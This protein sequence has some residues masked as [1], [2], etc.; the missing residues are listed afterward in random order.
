MAKQYSNLSN[1][2]VVT[3]WSNEVTYLP[4]EIKASYVTGNLPTGYELLGHVGYST[5]SPE[6][7]IVNIYKSDTN[8]IRF[9]IRNMNSNSISL[10]LIALVLLRKSG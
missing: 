2:L 1:Y 9:D 7:R 3:T 6:V 8:R 5:G 4:N 10:T